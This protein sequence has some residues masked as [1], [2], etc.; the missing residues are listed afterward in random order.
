MII[1]QWFSLI[2][3]SCVIAPFE[4]SHFFWYNRTAKRGFVNPHYIV[5]HNLSHHTNMSVALW[6][7]LLLC[8]LFISRWE[9]QPRLYAWR[10]TQTKSPFTWTTYQQKCTMFN[11]LNYKGPTK[12][13]I[14]ILTFKYDKNIYCYLL[15]NTEAAL[16]GTSRNSGHKITVK[17]HS[18]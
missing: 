6:S 18:I 5:L 15:L 17:Q 7:R 2:Y 1:Y 14:D 12:R 9:N 11:L 4:N 16:V 3:P 10:I 8:S 13:G